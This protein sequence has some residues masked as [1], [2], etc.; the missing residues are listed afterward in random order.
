[1]MNKTITSSFLGSILLLACLGNALAQEG[2]SLSQQVADTERAF[3]QTMAERDFEAFQA[4]LSDEAIFFAGPAPLRGKIEV[5]DAWFPYFSDEAP[6]FS[7]EPETVVVLDSGTL[8][9]SS[10][11]VLDS[12]GNRVATFNSVWRLEADGH[13]KI[14]FDKGNRSCEPPPPVDAN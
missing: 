1:M 9:L 2:D 12:S 7:W 6:P 13:W 5:S 11:P 4:F 3:A 8:A 14:I 10:G